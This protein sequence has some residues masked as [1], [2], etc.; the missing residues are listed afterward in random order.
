MKSSEASR[1]IKDILNLFMGA[2]L[3]VIANSIFKSN[4]QSKSN[5]VRGSK[6]E[7]KRLGQRIEQ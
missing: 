6:N 3:G 4:D 1:A 2:T 7:I 5:K